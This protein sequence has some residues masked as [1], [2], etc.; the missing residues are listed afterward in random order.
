MFWNSG[1]DC[2]FEDK[3]YLLILSLFTFPFFSIVSSIF[4]LMPWGCQNFAFFE[5]GFSVNLCWKSRNWGGKLIVGEFEYKVYLNKDK[6]FYTVNTFP[7]LLS[8]HTFI[9]FL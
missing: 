8:N 7:R 6:T 3:S 5:W 9:A 1:K 2:G 4:F